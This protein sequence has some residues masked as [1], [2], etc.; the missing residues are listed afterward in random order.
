MED[1]E[2]TEQIFNG[3]I[4]TLEVYTVRLPDGA[5]TK[6][7]VIRHPGAVAIVAL[8]TDQNVLLVKQFRSGASQT[9]LEIPAG[10]LE[11]GEA[12]DACAL[13]ELREETGFAA[14]QMEALG[15]LHTA[16]GYTNE[17][18]HLYYATDLIAAPLAQDADEFIEVQRVP[19]Q[20]A[21]SMIERSNI[22]DAKSVIGLLRVARML[23]PT[24]P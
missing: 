21:L 5:L 2:K 1:I 7:E 20:Q 15:G 24:R 4:V 12:P 22:T 23:N 10:L 9:M 8:D 17:Y 11:R 6:R 19:F 18:I 3:R 13:R 14:R 16:P